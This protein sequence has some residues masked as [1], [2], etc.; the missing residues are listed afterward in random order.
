MKVKQ[1]I[2]Q[3]DN[4]VFHEKAPLKRSRATDVKALFTLCHFV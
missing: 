3:A 1:G 4:I 2:W